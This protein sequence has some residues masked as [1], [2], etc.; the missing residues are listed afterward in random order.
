MGVAYARI[1][2]GNST[3]DL[4]ILERENLGELSGE[5]ASDGA[6]LLSYM[7]PYIYHNPPLGATLVGFSA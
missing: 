1:S 6:G 7:S 2:A 5:A 4:S 3:V